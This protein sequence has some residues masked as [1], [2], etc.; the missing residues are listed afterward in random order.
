MNRIYISIA[1]LLAAS[2]FANAELLELRLFSMGSSSAADRIPFDTVSPATHG[3]LEC[4]IVWDTDAPPTLNGGSFTNFPVS[5]YTIIYHDLTPNPN[6]DIVITSDVGGELEFRYSNTNGGNGTL[7]IMKFFDLPA[8]GMTFTLA[9]KGLQGPFSLAMTSLPDTAIDY[10]IN[11]DNEEVDEVLVRLI[12]PGAF[13]IQAIN[14]G[15]PVN[16]STVAFRGRAGSAVRYT[17]TTHT[18]PPTEPCSPAD[19]NADGQ[20][21]FFDISQFLT[22][23]GAGCP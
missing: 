7:E 16:A 5:D 3:V 2:N 19:F 17:V 9:L 23:F 13:D 1:T 10:T 11:A 22:I 4:V 20:L 21:D 12:Q 8:G 18:P 14:S 6:D 15:G